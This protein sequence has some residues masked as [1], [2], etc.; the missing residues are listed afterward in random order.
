MVLKKVTT[1]SAGASASFQR[2]LVE[3]WQYRGLIWAFS[4][5]DIKVK[6][7]QT[8]FGPAWVVMTPLITVGVMTFVFGL[9]IKVPSDGLPY[10]IF[11]LVAIIPWFSFVNVMNQTMSS[12]ESQSGLISKIYFPRLVIGASYALNSTV[13][14]LVG[15][16]VAL[17]FALYFSLPVLQFILMMPL[18]LLIQ[19]ALALGIGLLLAPYNARYR[20]VKHAIPLV[21]QLYYFANP[22]M[23]PVSVAPPWA[24]WVFQINPFAVVISTYRN[25]LNGEGVHWLSLFYAF[26][27]SILLLFF[28]A[29]LFMRKEQDLVDVL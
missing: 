20:D 14:Y 9:L 22:I 11:Y 15:Y 7:F 21:I 2:F 16:V 28:G 10:L 4:A 1:V 8:F 17:G 23:Y 6:Y 12:L 26:V 25:V 19:M 13:D 18:L 24:K 29:L 3:L 27:V 5:R